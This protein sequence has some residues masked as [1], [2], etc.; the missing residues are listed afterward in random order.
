[1]SSWGLWQLGI[2]LCLKPEKYFPPMHEILNI[3]QS[4]GG[5]IY[6]DDPSDPVCPSQVIASTE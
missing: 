3:N 1:M 4:I 6:F 5:E 2:D